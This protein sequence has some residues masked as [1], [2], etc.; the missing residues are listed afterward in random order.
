MEFRQEEWTKEKYKQLVAYLEGKREEKYAAFHSSLIPGEDKILGIRIPILRDMAKEISKG[1]ALSYLQQAEF[2]YNEEKILTGAVIGNLKEKQVG[3]ERILQEIRAFV[4]YIDN[5]SVCDTFCSSLKMT[6]RHKEEMF[7]F[8]VPYAKSERAYDRRFA[9]VMFLAYF[10]E[11][12]YLG[13]IFALCD[14]YDGTEYYVQMAIAWLVS[15]AYVKCKED[16][17]KY[18]ECNQL[19][20]VTYRMSLQKIIESNRVSKEEKEIMR[21]KKKKR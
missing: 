3:L 15:V 19:D 5:W 21:Q 14:A 13:E 16:T 11:E 1:N 6:K 2:Q 17:C 8:L 20:D 4:P 10:M 18:L 9:F 12:R 7:A